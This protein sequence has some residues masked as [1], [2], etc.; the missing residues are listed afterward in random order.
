MPSQGA[1]SLGRIDGLLMFTVF[2]VYF[3][4]VAEQ[5][6]SVVF[7]VVLA[8]GF[9]QALGVLINIGAQLE[10]PFNTSTSRDQV[11]AVV[12]QW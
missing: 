4:W 6:G 1:R 5:T 2:G 7:A 10:D 9:G 8:A 12:V 3:A 11:R